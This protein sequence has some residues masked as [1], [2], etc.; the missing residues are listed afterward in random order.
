MRLGRHMPACAWSYT[1]SRSRCK[2]GRLPCRADSAL[3]CIKTREANGTESRRH[4][5]NGCRQ[6]ALGTPL[7]AQYDRHGWK[8][9]EP[10]QVT[11]SWMM[12]WASGVPGQSTAWAPP[13][14]TTLNRQGEPRGHVVSCSDQDIQINMI[15]K[16]P[17]RG[18][19]RW[20]YGGQL[21]AHACTSTACYWPQIKGTSSRNTFAKCYQG[22]R[23]PSW[24]SRTWALKCRPST[25]SS[26]PIL[27]PLTTTNHHPAQVLMPHLWT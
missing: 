23:A 24:I 20:S 16:K 21:P 18:R 19:T 27:P 17:I 22:W 9:R 13:F 11:G 14:Q 1:A 26:R 4:S 3:S 12:G 25:W 10:A 2:C 5:S 15:E 6:L 8:H 7:Q